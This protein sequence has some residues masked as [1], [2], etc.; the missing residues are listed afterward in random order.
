MI[1][2]IDHNRMGRSR[3]EWLDSHFHFSFAEYYNPENIHYGALRVVNDDLIKAG[4]G[5]DEHPHKNMEIITYVV[6]GELTHA[7]SMQ[8][9]STL[10]RGEVQY[11]SAGT[12]VA[13][14]EHNWGS[15]PLRLLQIWI[16][17]DRD[18]YEPRY[19]D[20]RFIWNDRKNRWLHIVSGEEGG[21]P[22]KIHQDMNLYVSAL[23]EGQQLAYR[24]SPFR[25]AYLIQIEGSCEINGH[26]LHERD[27]AEICGENLTIT[28]NS[29]DAHILLFDMEADEED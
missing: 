4:T 5:F 25:Q 9:R 26:T 23:S 2:T 11:M 13:H 6:D 14:S 29:D 8:N 1:R 18:G 20:M 28:S 15:G 24:L 16:L 22:V 21:A 27:A 19:G 10:H 12:G 3:L 17:P 7:D